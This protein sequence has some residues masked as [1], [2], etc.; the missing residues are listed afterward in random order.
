MA[1]KAE[2]LRK[3]ARGMKEILECITDKLLLTG[4]FGSCLGCRD[5]ELCH[6]IQEV[7]KGKI[8]KVGE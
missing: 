2:I 1:T 7:I 3:K 8:E 4:V 6:Q 5:K